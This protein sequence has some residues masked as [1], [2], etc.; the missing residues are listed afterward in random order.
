M[1]FE[2]I[3]TRHWEKLY[4]F[5]F[6]MTKDEQT[7][8]NIV[9]DIFTDLWER[10]DSLKILSIENYLFRAAKNL[11]LKEYRKNRFNVTTMEEEFENYVVERVSSDD[12]EKIDILYSL[13]ESLPEKRKKILIMNKLQEM[14]IEQIATTLNIS[15]QTVKNQLSAA[16]KQLR[17]RAGEIAVII[18]ASGS[19]ALIYLRIS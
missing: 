19:I 11:V 4:T 3:Y 15:R 12:P 10:K 14:D 6:R 5:C 17:F 9:Q 16:L 7:S 18:F 8:Q 13:L 2:E 1:N